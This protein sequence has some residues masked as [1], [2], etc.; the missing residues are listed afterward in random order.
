MKDGVMFVD[1]PESCDKCLYRGTNEFTCGQGVV[2]DG[3][4]TATARAGQ[5]PIRLFDLEFCVA[6]AERFLK[7]VEQPQQVVR[8][9][10]S[11][12]KLKRKK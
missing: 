1:I 8:K 12:K 3:T 11:T 5:C 7:S 10:K 2:L 4:D 9:K 6:W